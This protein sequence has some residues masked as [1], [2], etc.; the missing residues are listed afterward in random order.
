MFSVEKKFNKKKAAILS[1]HSYICIFLLFAKRTLY[2]KGVKKVRFA[3]H[4][5]I[6]INEKEMMLE[7]CIFHET[8]IA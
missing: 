1:G 8:G 6:Q 2:V 7:I 4:H 5:R 3:V